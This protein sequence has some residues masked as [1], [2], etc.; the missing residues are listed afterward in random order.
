M[1]FAQNLCDLMEKNG[2]GS[3]KLAKDIGVHTSTVSNWKDGAEPKLEH[4]SRLADYFEVSIDTLIEQ[5]K[6]GA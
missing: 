6:D 4:L 1:G 3:Y 2:V 5:D